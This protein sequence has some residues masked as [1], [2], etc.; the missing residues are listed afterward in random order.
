LEAADHLH[1]TLA[2]PLVPPL[3][4]IAEVEEEDI[5]PAELGEDLPHLPM[6]VVAVGA[7]IAALVQ[8]LAVGVVTEGVDAL[9]RVGR[10]MPVD[11]AV[12]EAHAHVMVAERLDHGTDQISPT[13]RVEGRVVS[14]FGVPETE[15]LMM[16]RRHHEVLHPSRRRGPGPHVRVVQVGIEASEVPSLILLSGGSL[17]ELD[18][19]VS[20]RQRIEPP[21]DEQAKTIVGEP[22]RVADCGFDVMHGAPPWCVNSGPALQPMPQGGSG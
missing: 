17:V 9:D 1:E 4:G 10:M 19:L 18:P 15:A 5:D 21:M 14:Q 3:L 22:T 7:E 2:L 6:Q 16:L 12:V 20:S 8:R 13:R 11:Q